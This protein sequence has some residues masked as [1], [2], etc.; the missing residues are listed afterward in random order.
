M[1]SKLLPL[2][3]NGVALPDAVS[4]NGLR[5]Y[6]DDARESL[7]GIKGVRIGEEEA[8]TV[9]CCCCAPARLGPKEKPETLSKLLLLLLL[10]L[11]EFKEDEEAELPVADPPELF[12]LYATPSVFDWKCCCPIDCCC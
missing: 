5:S 6:D 10:L 1:V 4:L 11:M 9:D 8:E 12:V 7:K 3:G 2:P